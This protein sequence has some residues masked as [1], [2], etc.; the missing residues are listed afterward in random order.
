MQDINNFNKYNKL[1]LYK[2]GLKKF[3]DLQIIQ[4][5]KWIKIKKNLLNNL[6]N[7]DYIVGILFLTEMNR[8]CK[9]NNILVHGY[10]ITC[11]LVNLFSNIKA[12]ILFGKKI[13]NESIIFL[14]NSIANNIDYLNSRV[15]QSNQ[16][17]K[18][19]N[20]NLSNLIIEISPLLNEIVYYKKKHIDTH[21]KDL[22]NEQIVWDINNDIEKDV[23]Y[24]GLCNKNCYKCW[25]DEILTKFIYILLVV[26]KF[27]GTG[28][29]KD[30]NLYKLGE[31][32]SNIIYIE[33]KLQSSTN[34]N[35]YNENYYQH[36]FA[37]YQDYKSKLLYSI[38]ELGINS[39]TIDEIINFLDNSITNKFLEKNYNK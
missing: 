22:K 28:N 19:I 5:T 36:L 26:A 17:R 37:N 3:T 25:V 31:Y 20:E 8:Y 4:E 15:D 18:K 32:Y 2:D 33:L 39:D 1:N 34:L 21:K 12:K 35:V 38:I 13:S 7:L 29:T 9:N 30:P 27:M 10:Y 24:N 16:I 23:H 14:F 11:A 6:D